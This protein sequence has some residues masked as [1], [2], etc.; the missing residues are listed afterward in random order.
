MIAGV[1]IP[2]RSRK[3]PCRKINRHNLFVN[4]CYAVLIELRLLDTGIEICEQFYQS[5][6]WET[7]RKIIIVRQKIQ[8]RPKAPGKQLSLF[9]RRRNL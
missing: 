9:F 7:S 3:R 4:K 5:A 2:T 1:K 8:V 6:S